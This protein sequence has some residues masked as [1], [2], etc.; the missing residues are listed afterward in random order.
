MPAYGIGGILFDKVTDFFET[1]NVTVFRAVHS[2]Y[3]SNEEWELSTTGLPGNRSDKWWHVAIGEAQ[4]IIDG[5]FV[6]GVTNEISNTT[7]AQRTGYKPHETNIDLFTDRIISWIDLKYIQNH[8]VTYI[9]S[10]L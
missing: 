3:V 8:F 5:T 2:D 1:L 9:L 7:G 10:L 6:G 4:G